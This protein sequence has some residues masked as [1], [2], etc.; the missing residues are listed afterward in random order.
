MFYPP[1][2]IKPG[3]LN[4]LGLNLHPVD[5]DAVHR[6]IEETIQRSQQALIL[7][8]NI[9]AV[10]LALQN[11]WFK[12]FVNAGQLVFCDGDGVRWGLRC[13][14]I[15]PPPKVTYNVWMWQLGDFCQSRGY[16]LYFL[17]GKPGVAEEARQKMLVR[18]PALKILGASDGYFEKRGLETE[19]R[20]AEIN[21]LAPDILVTGFGMPVQEK[22]LMENWGAV[23]AHIFLNGGAVFDFISGRVKRAPEWL[24]RMEMEWLYRFYL[25][26]KRL[27][28]RYVFGNPYFFFQIFKE[29][30]KRG[31][32]KN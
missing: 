8:L 10:N 31:F 3:A 17:G 15:H 23:K 21:R 29:K 28:K 25:E 9:N 1:A 2:P 14:G 18:F 22:W 32:R 24:V 13:L 5:A 30:L 12:E 7:N 27:F 11:A 4:I 19:A 20:I 16:S 26:P 6:F